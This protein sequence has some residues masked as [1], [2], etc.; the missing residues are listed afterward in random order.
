MRRAL[1]RAA[2]RVASVDAGSPSLCAHSGACRG[3]GAARRISLLAE[4]SDRPAFSR[5]DRD[6]AVRSAFAPMASGP[7]SYSSEAEP[8]RET[9]A[10]DSTAPDLRKQI[11]DLMKGACPLCREPRV[12]LFCIL[13]PLR[14]MCT[15]SCM[16]MKNSKMPLPC[17]S[18][19]ERAPVRLLALGSSAPITLRWLSHRQK[20]P[21][22]MSLL[23][24]PLAEWKESDMDAKFFNALLEFEGK[25]RGDANIML[26]RFLHLLKGRRIKITL[27]MQFIPSSSFS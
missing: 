15:Y 27:A 22:V 11:R 17:I 18:Y 9:S 6:A 1:L 12:H 25:R 13:Q 3:T 16:Q 26:R 7:R 21:R 10:A 14:F 24:T 19:G 4:S 5:S 2:Q 8:T 23:Q 20:W